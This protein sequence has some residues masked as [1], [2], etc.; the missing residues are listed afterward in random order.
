MLYRVPVPYPVPVQTDDGKQTAAAILTH[1]GLGVFTHIGFS[2]QNSSFINFYI[3]GGLSYKGLIPMRDSDILGLA[4]AYGHLRNNAQDN[5]GRS[6]PGCEIVFET[7]YQIE[8]APWLSLQPDLQY[9][10]HPSGTD[11]A[12]AVVLGAHTTVSF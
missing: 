3:D 8:V 5:E 4:I 11:I 9:V 1:K 12:N 6:N 2:P 10:I 7:T